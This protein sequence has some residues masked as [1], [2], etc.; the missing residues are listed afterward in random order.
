MK[1]SI[2]LEFLWLLSKFKNI[3]EKGTYF[4]KRN[5]MSNYATSF[6]TKNLFETP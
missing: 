1:T 3:L 4:P 6:S 2:T 5:K